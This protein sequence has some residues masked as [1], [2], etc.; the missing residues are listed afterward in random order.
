MP[1]ICFEGYVGQQPYS[2][3]MQEFKISRRAKITS[4]AIPNSNLDMLQ[5]L[6]VENRVYDIE[7]RAIGRDEAEYYLNILYQPT[8]S[9]YDPEGNTIT[10]AVENISIDHRGGIPDIFV[11][12]FTIIET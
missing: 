11:F 12:K 7:A 5:Y 10:G 3:R 4:H 1:F 2:F 9:F 6:G 8:I